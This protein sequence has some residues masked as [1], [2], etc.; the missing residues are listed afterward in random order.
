MTRGAVPGLALCCALAGVSVWLQ[1]LPWVETNLRVSA[2]LIVVLLGI[3][4]ASTLRLPSLCGEGIVFAQKPVLRWAVAGLGFKLSLGEIAKIGGPALAVVVLATGA[5]LAFGWWLGVRM[6]LTTKGSALLAVGG[7]VCGASAIVAADSVLQAE[8]EEAAVSLAVVTL[9]GTVGLFLFP[10]MGRLMHMTDFG[11]GVW[12]GASLQEM[13][14]VVAG[15]RGFGEHAGDVATVTKLARIAL[16]APIVFGLAAF[17]RRSG[18]EGK[19]A[20]N[21]VPWFL[22]VF[23]VFATVNSFGVVPMEWVKILLDI[24]TFLLCVGMAGVGLKTNVR[25]L[26]KA[27]WRPIVVGLVQWIALCAIALGLGWMFHI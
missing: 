6:G 12:C 23:L 26:A 14:Q 9:W 22:V 1:K 11:Y 16:L 15:G 25:D 20:G 18:A 10:V 7:S 13:A 4:L 17:V 2:L 21:I 8:G 5:A 27:G 24:D 3:L 19:V